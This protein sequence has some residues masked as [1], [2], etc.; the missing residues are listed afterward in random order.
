MDD[1]TEI[2]QETTQSCPH[3]FVIVDYY[4]LNV[5]KPWKQNTPSKDS[6]SLEHFYTVFP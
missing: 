1:R 6:L 5:V 4:N 3:L 2:R